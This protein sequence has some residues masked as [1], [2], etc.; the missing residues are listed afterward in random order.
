MKAVRI[1]EYGGPEVLSYEDIDKPEPQADQ[2]V[3]RV[4]AAAVNMFDLTVREGRFKGPL[5]LPKTIGSDGAGVVEQ[6]GADVEGPRAGDEVMFTGLGIGL[7]G[8]YAEYAIVLP[9]QAVPK[10]A[11]LAFTDAAAMGLV[12][13]T[14]LYALT[15][16][17]GLQPGET[18]L[19]Q[20]AAGGVGS[21]AVQLA[22]ALGA[23]VLA[24]VLEA[25]H[26]DQVRGLGA[27][28]VV[29]WDEPEAVD[30]IKELTEG[31]GVDVV[32]EI[33]ASDNLAADL[34]L[35]AKG[36]RIAVVGG[37]SAAEAAVPFGAASGV[38]ASLL[39]L[40][41]S[42]AGR[43]GMAQMLREVGDMVARG[44]VR[45]VVCEVLPLSEAGRAHRRLLEPHFGK[46]VL[47]P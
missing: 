2:L 8:S 25:E 23:R 7:Q 26:V 5:P 16:R 3:V 39:Y 30:R 1:H 20:G 38:D 33:A 15:R 27:D 41:S 31:R 43:A 29:R 9:V 40:S 45:P 13:P 44:E 6:A 22:R 14:A 21:A 18:V 4:E 47:A 28:E 35:V 37:G 19:V 34:G 17:A 11:G 32:L 46:I 24:T 36:G 42:N 10:P 12:F